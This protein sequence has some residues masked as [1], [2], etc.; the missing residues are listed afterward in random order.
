MARKL[1]EQEKLARDLCWAGFTLPRKDT[2][3]N[4][5]EGV[6]QE[7]KA[8]YLSDAG[9]MIWAIRKLGIRRFDQCAAPPR[10]CHETTEER[11]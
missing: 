10:S 3:A 8:R 5:W 7:A 11:Q 9:Y 6:S 2:K 1:S 4:Y